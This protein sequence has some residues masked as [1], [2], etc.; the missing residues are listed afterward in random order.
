M[1]S[2]GMETA[3]YASYYDE[4]IDRPFQNPYIY[5]T[6]RSVTIS[7]L[8]DFLA[9]L[10]TTDQYNSQRTFEFCILA[11]VYVSPIMYVWHKYLIRRFGTESSAALLKMIYDQFLFKPVSLVMYLVIKELIRG[12][13]FNESVEFMQDRYWSL[14]KDGYMVWPLFVL[15]NYSFVATHRQVLCRQIMGLFWTMYVSYTTH[16]EKQKN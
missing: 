4:Q 15:L 6:V 9:Q 10:I 1:P 11:F 7:A 13:S 14:L 8:A 5:H 2:L 16:L 12:K 3:I